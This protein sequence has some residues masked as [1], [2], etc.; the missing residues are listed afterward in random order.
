MAKPY[1]GQF[2]WVAQQRKNKKTPAPGAKGPY[3]DQFPWLTGERPV[4]GPPDPR[5]VAPKVPVVAPVVK[6][7][8]PKP[9]AKPKAAVSPPVAPTSPAAAPVA[10]TPAPV[11]PTKPAPK[12]KPKAKPKGKPATD[13]PASPTTPTPAAPATPSTA[14][15]FDKLYAP[16]FNEISR[17]A[18]VI[19]R[20]RDAR[21]TDLNAFRDWYT[22]REGTAQGNLNQALADS[23]TRTQ[24]AIDNSSNRLGNYIDTVRASTAINPDVNAASGLDASLANASGYGAANAAARTAAENNALAL[25]QRQAAQTGV[26]TARQANLE[27]GA[28]ADYLGRISGLDSNR[29]TLALQKAKDFLTYTQNERQ[30]AAQTGLASEKNKIDAALAQSLIGSRESEA[31]VAKFNAITNR[32]TAKAKIL[33]SKIQNQIN[34]QKL[35][36]QEARLKI[37]QAYKA[38][39]LSQGDRKLLLDKYRVDATSAAAAAKRTASTEKDAGN[40]INTYIRNNVPATSTGVP[41]QLADLS[42]DEQVRRLVAVARGLKARYGGQ[43]PDS[44]LLAMATAPFAQNV[45]THGGV[46]GKLIS[47]FPQAGK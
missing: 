27:S 34:T 30:L 9:K 21:M 20:T 24:Q 36:L 17:Q 16:A 22:G 15:I 3:N 12:P 29:S 5:K 7:A 39:T 18:D 43:I 25:Q 28:Q 2:P 33:D 44:K 11:K 47:I 19:N 41:G 45:V 13:A 42:E 31:N 40:F 32:L 14:E 4:A 46:R 26:D 35:N 37:D 38:G 10:A 8:K 23:N 1:G 6:G